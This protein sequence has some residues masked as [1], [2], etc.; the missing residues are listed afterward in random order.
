VVLNHP[1]SKSKYKNANE[2]LIDR[3]LEK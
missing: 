1:G 3:L 2:F